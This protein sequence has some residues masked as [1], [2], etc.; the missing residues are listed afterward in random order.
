[1]ALI[2][3]ASLS[4]KSGSATDAGVALHLITEEQQQKKQRLII[5]Q[6]LSFFVFLVRTN[7][8]ISYLSSRCGDG[9]AADALLAPPA[10]ASPAAPGRFAPLRS[11]KLSVATKGGRRVSL[12]WQRRLA[13]GTAGWLVGLGGGS[14]GGPAH[15]LETRIG[16]DRV[17]RQGTKD[18]GTGG[19]L[20]VWAPVKRDWPAEWPAGGLGGGSGRGPAKR[21]EDRLAMIGWGGRAP[22]TLGQG[23]G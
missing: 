16:N 21:L 12:D 17:G 22:K 14:G 1:M 7:N 20:R 2:G 5:F 9:F 8:L 23:A 6:L 13:E 11:V 3:T 19:W 18:I 15:A 10:L 4:K